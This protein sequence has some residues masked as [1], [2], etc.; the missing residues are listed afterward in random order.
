MVTIIT[1]PL[2]LVL[3]SRKC[4]CES[5]IS[6]SKAFACSSSLGKSCVKKGYWYGIVNGIVTVSQC[7]NLFCDF[8][9]SIRRS[10]CPTDVVPDS[11]SYVLLDQSLDD[12]CADGHGGPLC[13]G[14]T[15]GKVP[16]YDVLQCIS[17]D[18]CRV[19][20][21]YVMMLLYVLCPLT[22]GTLLLFVIQFKLGIGSG[23]LYGPIFYLAVL[24]RMPLNISGSITILISTVTDSV[25]LNMRVLGFIPLC[26]FR[27]VSPM[28]IRCLKLLPPL[29]VLL[30]VLFVA[31]C[32][33]RLFQRLFR[34]LPTEGICSLIVISFW[35]LASTSVEIV[36]PVH[37]SGIGY[38]VYFSPDLVYLKTGGHI[39]VWTVATIILMF[40]C[41][42]TI[43]LM[44]SPFIS[45]L[46]RIKPLLDELQSCYKD[47]Y[48]WY[49]GV[50][51]VSWIVLQALLIVLDYLVFQTLIMMLTVAQISLLPYCRRW[52][53][54]MNTILL[55]SLLFTSSL[56]LV[57]DNGKEKT[58]LV[59]LSVLIP[60]LYLA[61]GTVTLVLV[62]IGVLHRIKQYFVSLWRKRRQRRT[63]SQG[64]RS[65][66]VREI[67]CYAPNEREPLIA[68][69]QGDND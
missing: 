19:W 61:V 38:R 28:Y 35:S 63:T 20:H 56:V 57:D 60:L 54:I 66:V 18:H 24:N 1:C 49:G 47:Q 11:T 55:V 29:V 64:L 32:A 14:C 59:H 7:H 39:I 12:Q 22:I 33:P 36:T 58:V 6:D 45:T 69:L 26:F 30:L 4:V 25:L 16:T 67:Q 2:G 40:L 65:P 52:L 3:K 37:L 34:K 9:T 21:P 31:K 15:E 51:F 13:T 48:R 43:V 68:V 62:R 8:S 44:V 41:G 53:N 5:D 10:V 23:Y 46:H 42:V 27:G 50:Y 17:A